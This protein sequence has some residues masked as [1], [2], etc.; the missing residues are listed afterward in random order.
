M[1]IQLTHAQI[2]IN[3]IAADPGN[4]DGQGAEW[5]ELYNAGTAAVD[6]SCY[7][8]TD[9]EEIILFPSGTYLPAGG[10]L[11]VY[12]SNFFSCATCNWDPAI[13]ALI[14]NV[15]SP[16]S[17]DP[18]GTTSV[19]VATCGCTNQTAA[20]CFAVTWDNGG[21][22]DR[23]ALFDANATIVDA[24]YWGD[25]AK[26]AP[27]GAS[28]PEGNFTQ[29]P[30]TTGTGGDIAGG[31]TTGC[32]LPAANDYTIPALPAPASSNAVWEFA[33]PDNVGCTTSY[34][35][36]INGVGSGQ[37]DWAA[38]V[39]PTP[40]QSNTIADYGISYAVSGGSAI[41]FTTSDA[42]TI[43]VCSGATLTFSADINA[44]NQVFNDADGDAGNAVVLGSGSLINAAGGLSLT[45][46]AWTEA[47]IT[48]AGVTNLSYTTTAITN[49]TTITL[50]IKENTQASPLLNSNASG[51]AGA[52]ANIGGS[53]AAGEC[54]I[55]KVI[56][57]N[58]VNP[59]TAISYTCTNGVVTVTTTPASGFGAYNLFLD[60]ST[61]NTLDRNFTVTASPFV[62]SVTQGTATDYTLTATGPQTPNCGALPAVT[63]GPLCVFAPPCPSFTAYDACSTA[64]GAKCP[65]DVINLSLTGTN[66]PNG[67][68]IQWVNDTNNN[69]NVYDEPVSS[70]IATQSITVG[71]PVPSGS[72]VLN[73]VLPD[74][75]IETS[76]N[77]GEGWEIAGTPGTG[78]GCYYFTDGDWVVQLP[79]TAVIP[80]NGFYVVG[81]NFSDAGWNTHIDYTLTASSSAG[82]FPNLTNPGTNGEFLVMFNASNAFVNGVYWGAST[83]GVP[84]PLTTS[85]APATSGAPT[86]QVAGAGCPA[87]PANA[88]IQTAIQSNAGSVANS[89]TTTS[90][91]EQTVER[92]TDVTGTWQLSA[93]PGGTTNTMGG[94]NIGTTTILSPT[95]AAYNIPLSACNTTLNIKPRISPDQTGCSPGSASPTLATRTYT[96]TCPTAGITGE[97]AI[98]AAASASMP[99]V[100]TNNP[101][102]CTN[103]IIQYSVNGGATQSFGPATISGGIVTVTGLNT[104]TPGMT[105]SGGTVTLVG[106][107][108]S[109]GGC[110]ACP[111]SLSG[112]FAVTVAVNPAAPVASSQDIC[113]GQASI[114]TATGTD[115]LNWYSDAGLTTQIGSGASI[116]YTGTGSTTLYVQSTNPDTGCKSAST[117]VVVTANPVPSAVPTGSSEVCAGQSITLNAGASG[118]TLTYT[119]FWSEPLTGGTLT[120]INTPTTGISN[121]VAGDAGVY[122]VLVTDSK[123]CYVRATK[124]VT[125]NALPAASISGTTSYCGTAGPATP[126]TASGGDTY[127][128][129]TNATTAAITPDISTVGQT[130]YT[131][132]VT[133]SVTGCSATASTMVSV[134]PL[135]NICQGATISASTTGC[136]V[137]TPYAQ[138][139]LLTDAAGLILQIDNVVTDCAAT[140]A[141]ALLTAGN[142]YHV[143]AL[144]YDTTNP[145]SPNYGLGVNVN[146]IGSITQGCYNTD[147]FLP[148]YMC[149]TIVGP[150]ACLISGNTTVCPSSANVYAVA[151]PMTGYAWSISG[152]GSITGALNG[153]SVTVTAGTACSTPFTLSVTVTDANGCTSSCSQP[154]DV[155]DATPPAIQ[156]CAAVTAAGPVSLACNTA[157]SSAMALAAMGAI[158]DNC[159]LAAGSPTVT[160]GVVTGICNKTQ[161]FT[162]SAT[163]LCGSTTSCDITYTWT[164]D[165]TAPSFALCTDG[166]PANNTIALG[167]N[168]AGLPTVATV[169]AAAGAITEGCGLGTNTPVASVTSTSTVAC[170]TTQVWTVSVT[171]ACGNTGSCDITYTWTTD[172]TAPSFA[173]CPSNLVLICDGNYATEI[174]NWLTTASATDACGATIT[175]S[176][177]PAAISTLTCDAGSVTVIFTA[178]DACGNTATCSSQIQFTQNPSIQ[179][180]K[181]ISS[182]TD[183][184]DGVTG[185]GDIINYAFTVT[186]TGNVTLTNITLN[187]PLI[188]ETGGPIGSLAPGASNST[189]FTGIYIITQ[190]DVNTGYVQ[191]TA[192]VTGVT[193]SGGSVTDISDAGNDTVETPSGNGGTNGNPTDDPTVQ[194]LNQSP[195]IQLYKYAVSV[196]DVNG[197]GYNDA[198][199]VV[200]YTFTVTN[201]GNVTLY[202]IIVAD[203]LVTVVGAPIT[204]LLPG[205]SNSTTFT[206]T[207][208]ITAADVNIGYVE[209]TATVTGYEADGT[210][211]TDIS[212]AGNDATETGDGDGTTNGNPTDDPTVVV[213]IPPCT[214]NVSDIPDEEICQ[215]DVTSDNALPFPLEPYSIIYG[216]APAPAVL[217]SLTY[218]LTD[219]SGNILQ[220][221]NQGGPY[222]T[223][224]NVPAFTYSGLAAGNYRVYEVIYLTTDGSLTNTGVGNNI[225]SVGLTNTA[226]TCLDATFAD[227]LIHP[228]P[229]VVSLTSNS[230]LCSG[231]N[232]LIDLQATNVTV[233]GVPGFPIAGYQWDVPV[234]PNVN[235]EDLLIN[236]AT[237]ADS[238]LYTVTITDSFGCSAT[239][240][241]TATVNQTPVLAEV[242]TNVSCNGG[243]NGTITVS[244]TPSTGA[245]TYTWSAGGSTSN[246]ASGLPAGTYTVTATLNG[247]SATISA[248]ITQPTALTASIINITQPNCFNGVSADNGTATVDVTGGTSPYGYLW[249]SGAT[250]A[251]VSNLAPGNYSVTVTDFNNCT[252][253]LTNALVLNAPDCCTA[254]VSDIPDQEICQ[255]YTGTL[256]FPLEP[257][258]SLYGSAPAPASLYS[259]T[260]VLTTSGG[261]ILQFANMGAPYNT[262]SN[263]PPFTYSGLAAGNYRVYEIIWRTADGPLVGLTTGGNVAVV[264][265]TN[266]NSNCLDSTFGDLYVN[267]A[268]VATANSNSPVCAGNAL[269]LTATGGVSYAW[270]STAAIPF[271]S[272][273]NF[274]QINAASSGNSGTYTVTVTA[275][276][277]TATAS[278]AVTVNTATASITAGGA[279]TFCSG[280]SVTLTASGGGTYLWST[281]ATTEAITATA[282]GTYTV[283]VTANGCTATASQTVTVNSVTASIV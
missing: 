33:G 260:Y 258:G 182:L 151:T 34:G 2:V 248:T 202:N 84:S 56:T 65:G 29:G 47:A 105:A 164:T 96:V 11:L 241:T 74:A 118:G 59:V 150:P 125:V 123:N 78:I 16:A 277:C 38:D 4:Y 204:S 149:Y 134:N 132:T 266:P 22:T 173:V 9:G 215:G 25:G 197:N 270:S 79:S 49:A 160:P 44:F 1:P 268:P 13:S 57:V 53:G 158:S 140:F 66:L 95:C 117:P 12:N 267:P 72:P 276:G 18:D 121:A 240:S 135:F 89:N 271:S 191:N 83:A 244:P 261:T 199:D 87:L 39:W 198:G 257:Y 265:L 274:A 61:N 174:N 155:N 10:Y 122:T 196:N 48:T 252:V 70:I 232:L 211:V 162:I 167:C 104:G 76:P 163:N 101:V 106:V 179:L 228:R 247:C 251:T 200:H 69:N 218:L 60:N 180:Y 181:T 141:T 62:F 223:A 195:A 178:A 283:T 142:T 93:N 259:L 8:L 219:V 148:V 115:N 113:N 43:N 94:S 216:A 98:C 172:T 127:L 145:P 171:D 97:A 210:P 107:A 282:S 229:A 32:T 137:T 238:G 278:Q 71:E 88:S 221:S 273:S 45:N 31:G 19:D 233:N 184:G 124:S 230:P 249:T 54:Y 206:A 246:T 24:V 213:T 280:G 250:T 42:I 237:T 37:A 67:G 168:P 99:V 30:L 192:M 170:I 128:W 36:I 269:I 175:N 136:N 253:V 23:V 207:Y 190:A 234:G 86:L 186:N 143:Y 51:C 217:Y 161:T 26:E 116:A 279:T 272:T 6:I 58:V 50:K 187:D 139:F 264:D 212:D 153:A 209:N 214:A 120:S 245:Y 263:T 5:T 242:H 85:N 63:G 20:S 15:G 205:A 91:N 156:N 220:V 281:G 159:G 41:N 194:P 28:I 144:N 138:V 52:G 112:S 108:F 27:A 102:A 254:N 35:R 169:I 103:A 64:A 201:T 185:I 165:T 114:L 166:D 75:T 46:Q 222:N 100:I 109:G 40:G 131:V 157:P 77:F 7:V 129:S 275:N 110:T 224:S 243:T 226:S 119:Y 236:N 126:L 255:G 81:T 80:A 193:P 133:N 90:A 3:E 68:T 111:A 55:N 239:S 188:F 189:V 130:T 225:N 147:T 154:V 82:G 146:S 262:V 227:L 256:V 203:P 231:N 17:P 176:L 73:E 152:N 14:D 208:T 235:A 177:T 92:A 183:N 21:N